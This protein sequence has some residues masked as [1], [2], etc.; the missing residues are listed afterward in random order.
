MS[1]IA[2][3]ALS[4]WIALGPTAGVSAGPYDTVSEAKAAFYSILSEHDAA[5]RESITSA[6]VEIAPSFNGPAYA[7]DGGGGGSSPPPTVV[8]EWHG[9]DRP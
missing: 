7:T 5:W 4:L 9:E 3:L 6:R 8:W 2:G 1:D